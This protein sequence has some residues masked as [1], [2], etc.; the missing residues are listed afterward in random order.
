MKKIILGVVFLLTLV[1]CKTPEPEITTNYPIYCVGTTNELGE[2]TSYTYI[3][4]INDHELIFGNTN[5]CGF[6]EATYETDGTYTYKESGRTGKLEALSNKE[7]VDHAP[8][9]HQIGD[10]HILSYACEVTH[11][12]RQ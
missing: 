11:P 9:S 7:L 12:I 6:F 4:F 10:Q 8:T 5:L 3:E 2:D 1:G